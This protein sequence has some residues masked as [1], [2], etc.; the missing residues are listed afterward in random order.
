MYSFAW[1]Y[2]DTRLGNLVD[3]QCESVQALRRGA[4]R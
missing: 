1:L 2:G 3:L 4:L